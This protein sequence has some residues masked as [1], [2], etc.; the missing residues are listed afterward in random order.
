MKPI[1]FRNET[2][3]DVIS[4]VDTMRRA[5]YRALQLHGACTTRELAAKSG[6]DLLNVRPRVTELYQLG[7]VE[8]VNPDSRGG[9]GVYQ[10]VPWCQAMHRFEK[11]K[12]SAMEAQLPLL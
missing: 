6:I 1:D 8:L 4:R 10:A 7:L 3:A 9:E 2:W 12:K 5:V 11:E